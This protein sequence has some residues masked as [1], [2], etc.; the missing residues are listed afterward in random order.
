MT[1]ESLNSEELK[2][3]FLFPSILN[4]VQAL[5]FDMGIVLALVI[6]ISLTL[7]D[8]FDAPLIGLKVFLFFVI[9][10]IYE[11]FMSATGGTIGH[12][13]MGMTIRQ[14]EDPKR[15]L[16]IAQ[17]Y[18]RSAIKLA[19]GWISFLSVS[20]DPFRRAMHDKYCGSIILFNRH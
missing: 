20:F 6:L 11:P 18:F 1:N 7:L 14:F 16:S 8:S 4:R 10:F 17:A 9:L 15:K 13:T 5:F 3:E 12:R 19:L 2:E